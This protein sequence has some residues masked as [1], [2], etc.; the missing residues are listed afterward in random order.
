MYNKSIVYVNYSP[1]ENSGHI[2]DYLLENF[3]T[4]Y[5]FS[6]SFHTLGKKN[7]VNRYAVFKKGK[8]IRN[9]FMFGMKVP[10]G[11]VF[12][13]IP[14]RSLINTYQI[15]SKIHTI[16]KKGGTIDIFF[17]VNA[18]TA[19]I[20]RLL[21]ILRLVRI[22]LFWVWDYY[23]VKNTSLSIR[24]S[25]SLYSQFDRIATFSDKVVYL[26]KK[27]IEVRKDEGLIK[28]NQTCTIIPIG[29]GD[30]YPIKRKNLKKIRLGFIGVL[31]KSQ[32]LD[33]LLDSSKVLSKHF[34]NLTFDIIG[35][36]PDSAYFKKRVK[37]YRNIKYN[38]YGL[39]SENKFRHILYNAT[40]GI[41][42]YMPGDDTV[43]KYTDPGKPKR[44]LEFNLPII[45][46]DVIE[47]SKELEKSGCGEIIKYGDYEGLA[48]AIKKIINNYDTYV[49]NVI[50]LHNKYYYKK[51]Y[52]ALFNF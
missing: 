8:L 28:K 1:Y 7:E 10:E 44:Y 47:I 51:I 2:L 24:I 36:G 6:I 27:L 52:P 9:E 13:L 37:N 31:K 23:P 35:F 46:T 34:R 38:F 25:R 5:L 41:A 14:V 12:L 19:T 29:T 16:K 18:F 11:L 50:N 3:E 32:G 45:T 17:T 40:I 33:M 20:G 22:T 4:V 26:H 21:K 49:H 15:I 39:V 48:N 43:S 30:V 42:P